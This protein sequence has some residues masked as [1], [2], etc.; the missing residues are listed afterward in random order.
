[1]LVIPKLWTHC[2]QNGFCEWHLDF[3]MQDIQEYALL[4]IE[5]STLQ[6]C[7][8]LQS[9]PCGLCKQKHENFS[10]IDK[11][12][13]KFATLHVLVTLLYLINHHLTKDHYSI[14]T[15]VRKKQ[16]RNGKSKNKQTK[17]MK[18]KKTKK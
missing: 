7:A 12:M 3:W 2:Y 9:F 17:H 15:E 18:R 4:T 5:P 14:F 8:C 16:E 1:M 10:E 11:E 6:L 13:D